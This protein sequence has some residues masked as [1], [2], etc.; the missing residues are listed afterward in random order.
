[1]WPRFEFGLGVIF[2]LILLLFFT[3]L[4]PRSFSGYSL[5]G[6]PLFSKT[7]IIKN[8]FEFDLESVTD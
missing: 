8:I 2:G 4:A 1:M 7:N 5:S 3:V 6:F